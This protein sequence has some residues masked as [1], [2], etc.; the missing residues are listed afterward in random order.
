MYVQ[1]LPCPRSFD[2]PVLT[3]E[4]TGAVAD[5]ERVECKR[6]SGNK[7]VSP[8][9]PPGNVCPGTEP[10][11]TLPPT[12]RSEET[13]GSWLQFWVQINSEAPKY[14]FFHFEFR[15]TFARI[16]GNNACSLI[17]H[18]W[19]SFQ[20]CCCFLKLSFLEPCNFTQ[21]LWKSPMHRIVSDP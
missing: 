20:C 11:P 21:A 18:P 10:A 5:E 3:T 13:G 7:S 17:T 15:R 12:Q 19:R 8:E 1:Q 2:S 16:L 9:M 14:R 6:S 4:E